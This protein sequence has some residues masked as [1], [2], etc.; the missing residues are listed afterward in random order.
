[1]LVSHAEI[2]TPVFQQELGEEPILKLDRNVSGRIAIRALAC[3]H[4]EDF[5]TRRRFLVTS[6]AAVRVSPRKRAG[7]PRSVF[8]LV[9]LTWQRDGK[10][11]A[12]GKDL[13]EAREAFA[14]AVS[15][16]F[17][18]LVCAA[19]TISGVT[20]LSGVVL[21]HALHGI[22]RFFPN[23]VDERRHVAAVASVDV[24]SRV[25]EETLDV[26]VSV[27]GRGVM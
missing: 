6:F 10:V 27:G 24:D 17:T 8:D 12:L 20:M 3:I 16:G 21:Q 23:G 13:G 9:I 25:V 26:V 4:I 11:A 14:K 2:S 22:D 15:S 1:M 5:S 18:N 19:V 7:H